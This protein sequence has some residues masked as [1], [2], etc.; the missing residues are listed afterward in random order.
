MN[1]AEYTGRNALSPAF[2]DRWSMWRFVQLP[3]ESDLHAMLRHLVFG[4]H[5]AFEFR[6]V[7]YQATASTPTYPRLQ[8]VPQISSLLQRL[9]TFHHTL[10]VFSG[11]SQQS[12][13]ATIGRTRRERYQFTR[14]G[15]H[16]IMKLFN[17]L[18]IESFGVS[19][20]THSSRQSLNEARCKQLLSEVI[21]SI[22]ISK[23]QDFSDR[24]AINSAMRAAG[25]IED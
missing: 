15:L 8:E 5:P 25:L 17:A 19:E 14:R 21:D 20:L 22:Y 3:T 24:N 4:E 2:R 11:S 1:P 16:A 9:A 10:S 18:I 13:G 6:G 23:V 12:R 7:I